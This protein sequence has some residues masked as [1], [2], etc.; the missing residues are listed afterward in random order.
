MTE[1][2]HANGEIIET[3]AACSL[4]EKD[5]RLI[6][7]RAMMTLELLEKEGCRLRKAMKRN[8][9]AQQHVALIVGLT[10]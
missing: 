9:E 6:R 7:P 3:A 5:A 1:T 2:N 4:T 10:K 8:K